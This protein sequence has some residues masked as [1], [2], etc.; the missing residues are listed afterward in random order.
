M[1]SKILSGR[2][3]DDRY[4]LSNRLGEGGMAEV[5]LADDLRLGRQVAVK[6]L[7][8]QYASEKNLL[9]R[10]L[11]E[12]RSIAGFNH[13]N[14][15]AVY[16]VGRDQ[17]DYYIVMEYVPG[18]DLRKILERAKNLPVHRALEVAQQMSQGIGY[19]H[20]RGL[21]HRDVKPGNILITPDWRVKVADFGIAKA[22][23]SAGLTEPGVVW[24]T[25]SYLSP[26]QIRGEQ[27]TFASDVYA[28][29]IV[30]YEIISGVPPFQ[31]EDRVAIALQHLD[32]E[33]PPFDKKLK[34][35]EPVEALVHR[36][37]A[38]DPSI[39]YKNATEMARAIQGLL[40]RSKPPPFTNDRHDRHDRQPGV[41]G[42]SE[43]PFSSSQRP[44][45]PRR[46][47]RAQEP[48]Q[49]IQKQPSSSAING[50]HAPRTARSKTDSGNLSTYELGRIAIVLMLISFAFSAIML[51]QFFGEFGLFAPP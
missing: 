1:A 38:K 24:G 20:R 9:E 33:P 14:L 43:A 21:V 27:A 15:V 46:E 28:I 22:L 36:A 18:E 40:E 7:R 17:R 16:D 4:Q 30:L 11:N 42:R 25:T 50:V 5:Y 23:A 48:P 2:T 41:N 37:L 3:L 19:A 44:L 8:P 26:E 12:A 39:R 31:G 10:F 6:I 45:P 29:G 32:K 34:V 35:P 13:P 47:Y 49:N 51:A